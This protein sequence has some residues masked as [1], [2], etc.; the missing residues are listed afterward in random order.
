MRPIR[1]WRL[2]TSQRRHGTPELTQGAPVVGPAD[3][4]I[5]AR[6]MS[7]KPAVH[8]L[9]E[10]APTEAPSAASVV[11]TTAATETLSLRA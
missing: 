11:A 8:E 9:V 5:W 1:S 3:V 6:Q 2:R 7:P 4:A 10:V